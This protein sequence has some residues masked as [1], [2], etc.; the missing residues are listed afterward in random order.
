MPPPRLRC[1]ST[2]RRCSSAASSSRSHRKTARNCPSTALCITHSIEFY[3]SFRLAASVWFRRKQ[4]CPNAFEKALRNVF[5]WSSDASKRSSNSKSSVIRPCCAPQ[6]WK[7]GYHI[8][9]KAERLA[10][11]L[12]DVVGNAKRE[13]GDRR[14][15]LI[16]TNP[17]QFDGVDHQESLLLLV[18]RLVFRKFPEKS[19][20]PDWSSGNAAAD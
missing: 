6:S 11:Q 13:R 10:L 1:P 12:A 8:A 17:A 9:K 7:Q 4:C 20:H 14:P 19:T 3:G 18:L 2:A 16:L 15:L 5:K